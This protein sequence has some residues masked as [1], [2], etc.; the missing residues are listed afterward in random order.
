MKVAILLLLTLGLGAGAS[1]QGA[2]AG[3]RGSWRAE[4]YVL[5]TGQ[6]HTVQGLI[7]FTE[8]DWTVL[9]FVVPP[10]QAPQRGSAE[11]GTYT[12]ENDRLVF[13]HL[14]NLSTGKALDGLPESPLRMEVRDAAKAP[15]EPTRVEVAGGRLT[16]HFPSGN[17]MVF[18]RSAEP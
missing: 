18:A 3:V 13:T 11:G 9:F 10:G 7:F 16:L 17:Q 1:A 4:R 8:R 14:Y 5:K 2:G 6:T 15:R 12:I